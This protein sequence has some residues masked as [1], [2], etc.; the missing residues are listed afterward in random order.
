M[1]PITSPFVIKNLV[2]FF[3]NSDWPTSD[4]T[5]SKRNWRKAKNK[6]KVN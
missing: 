4:R 2:E 3:I 1:N 5:F 6:W